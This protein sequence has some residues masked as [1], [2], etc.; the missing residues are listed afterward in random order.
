MRKCLTSEL[1]CNIAD[2]YND[3]ASITFSFPLVFWIDAS[4]VGTITQ[5]LK[6]ICNLPEA[7]ADA[8]DGSLKSALK[9]IGSLEANYAMV[10]D[11]ADVLSPAEL[12]GYFPPGKKGNIL[13][14]SRNSAMRHLTLPENSLEVTDME[15]S[16][17]AELLLRASFLDT[18]RM[19]LQQE[20]LK[21][22]KELFCL[23]LA[24]DQAGA[25]IASGATNIEDYIAKYS[26]HRERL[27]SHTQCA[28]SSKYNRTVY[29]TWELSYKEI[30]FRAECDDLCKA[31]AAQSALLLLALFPF[32]HHEGISEEIFSYAAVQKNER[33]P[34]PGLP[35]ASSILDNRLLPLNKAGAWDNYIFREGLS[36]LLSF[37]LVKKG[38][39]D[40][41][42]CMHPLVH[43]WGKDR[44]SLDER[45]RCSLMAYAIL[46]C[47]LR[48]DESQP[49]RFRRALVTHVRENMQH[50]MMG[51][52]QTTDCYFDDAY[53]KF[54][55]LLRDQRYFREAEIVET[56]VLNARKRTLGGE[57]TD[58]LRAMANIAAT[59]G[60]LN[61][62]TE[63]EKLEMQILDIRN[64]ILGA[65]HHD[66]IDAMKNVARTYRG[67]KKYAEA[68]KLSIKVLDARKKL[69]G[70]EHPDTISAI[71]YQALTYYDLKKYTEAEKL[72]IQV[73]NASNRILGAEHPDTIMAMARLAVTYYYLEKYTE[74]EKLEI[75][76]VDASNR[77]LGAE[78]PDTIMAMASLVVTYCSLKKYSEAEK[79]QI[80]VVDARNRILGAEHPDTITAIAC[81]AV[82]YCSL[83]KY[84]EAENL[85][86]QVVDARN[87]ILGAEHPATITAMQNLAAT[88]KSLEKYTEQEQL[89]T[90]LMNVEEKVLGEEHQTSVKTMVTLPPSNVMNDK[91]DIPE[92]GTFFTHYF[93]HPN[94]HCNIN[95]IIIFSIYQEQFR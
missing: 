51:Q 15:E 94:S 88:F 21:I 76:V 3:R 38:P 12:E 60:R 77:I 90:Q 91:I 89:E 2:Q 7:Q 59:Y 6:G 22:V 50:N 57:H 46:S 63:A 19:D 29:G 11:N 71:G 65:E 72:E 30:Q 85:E 36:V 52:L 95:Q 68:E 73:V 10:F 20:A 34:R 64:R 55:W 5:H 45:Q 81:L 80:Q 31:Q 70:S 14:T 13:I 1:F 24:V 74:A 39:T 83:K 84:T 79:L 42:Y 9:W 61:R 86:I 67:L 69:L 93:I 35:L 47:S 66:T 82:T 48:G 87:R 25:F 44:M 49:Y 58:T 56:Q 53:E 75:Q 17:A 16:D 8:V 54:G 33:T 41:V 40:G 26:Q 23:P 92:K 78:H 32:F 18:S 27:L 43:A 4:S 37:C 62:Y 28:G